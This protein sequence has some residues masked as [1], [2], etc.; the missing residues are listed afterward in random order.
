M[1]SPPDQAA[2]PGTLAPVSGLA[3]HGILGF[4]SQFFADHRGWS[5]RVGTTIQGASPKSAF[6]PTTGGSAKLQWIYE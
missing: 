6:H 1:N 3:R 2:S 5:F 4:L